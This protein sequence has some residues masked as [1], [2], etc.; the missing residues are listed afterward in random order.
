M[1]RRRR[2]CDTQQCSRV[3]VIITTQDLFR[4]GRR[5]QKR[6]RLDSTHSSTCYYVRLFNSNIGSA[7]DYVAVGDRDIDTGMDAMDWRCK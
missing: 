7:N 2:F 6:H 1:H 4:R 5:P 3:L